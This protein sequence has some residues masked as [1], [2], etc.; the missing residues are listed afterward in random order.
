MKR[1]HRRLAMLVSSSVLTDF[2]NIW[3]GRYALGD[4][5]KLVLFGFPANDDTNMAD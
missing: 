5:L 3:Y 1:T 2:Y 4:C